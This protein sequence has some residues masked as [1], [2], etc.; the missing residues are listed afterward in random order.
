MENFKQNISSLGTSVLNLSNSHLDIDLIYITSDGTEPPKDKETFFGKIAHE[1]R[2]FIASFVEDYDTLG[3]VYEEGE[4]TRVIEVWL[5]S[6]RDQSA[7]LKNMIDEEFTPV[8]DIGVN[9]KL[10]DMNTL[11]PAVVAGTGPDIALTV[12]NDV[13]VEYALRNSSVDLTQFDDFEDILPQYNKEAFVPYTFQG[14]IYGIPETQNF[15]VIFYRS[16]ILENELGLTIPDDLPQTWDD[17]IALLPAL[18][19]NNMQFALPSTE[20]E[21]DGIKNPDTSAMLAFL[22]QNQAKLYNE[23]QTRTLLDEEQSVEAFEKYTRMYTHY[24]IPQKF[25]FVNRFRTGEMPIGVADYSNFN[26]LSVFAPEIR[27][28][29]DFA[30]MPGTLQEDGSIDRTVSFWGQASIMLT[31]AE[32]YD[33]CWTFLKWWADADTKVRFARELESIMGAAARYATANVKTF[34]N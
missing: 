2:S 22:F 29:W 28:L 26:T 34:E 4:D 1:V 31:D 7:I 23:E 9:V 8:Y 5:L 18:Q 11:L 17:V 27:G 15:N 33:A 25:D 10:I 24:G 30:L 32:D 19:E 6:G 16:D 13:P 3:N 14:G 20:R 21:I 12:N